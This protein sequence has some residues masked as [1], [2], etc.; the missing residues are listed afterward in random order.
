VLIAGIAAKE[1]R[2]L[3]RGEECGCHTIAGLARTSSNRC[4]DN[5]CT[6]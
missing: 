3:W 4:Q 6:K 1:G 5:S 2:E